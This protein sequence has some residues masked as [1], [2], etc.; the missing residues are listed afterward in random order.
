M[1]LDTLWKNPGCFVFAGV[2]VCMRAF[3]KLTGISAG[4]L[5]TLREK[6]KQG[7]TTVWRADSLAWMTMRNAAKA[8]KYIDC[9]IWLETYAETHGEKSPMS[10]RI[11]LPTGRKYF[12]H[13]QYDW[14]RTAGLGN[15]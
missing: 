11:Y 13:M 6:V 4:Q 8:K 12:F 1:L 7:I 14:E 2:R 9:R 3:Q 10:M 15:D 5:Q